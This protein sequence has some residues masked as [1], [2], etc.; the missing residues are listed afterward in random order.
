[1]AR[2]RFCGAEV[3]FLIVLRF[4]T[5]IGTGIAKHAIDGGWCVP[6]KQQTI[7]KKAGDRSRPILQQCTATD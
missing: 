3:S 7:Q 6:R 5:S 1:V 4:R 2:H